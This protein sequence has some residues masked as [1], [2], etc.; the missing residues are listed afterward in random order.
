MI[1]IRVSIKSFL[2]EYDVHFLL[3]L[4]EHMGDFMPPESGQRNMGKSHT[5]DSGYC[6]L[7][8]IGCSQAGNSRNNPLTCFTQPLVD[9]TRMVR[10]IF[11]TP[12]Q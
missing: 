4:T 6:Y 1:E 7:R 10:D 11:H 2:A 3:Y 5:L 12:I 9:K 8:G